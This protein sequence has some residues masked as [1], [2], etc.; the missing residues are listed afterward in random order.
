[1]YKV[2]VFLRPLLLCVLFCAAVSSAGAQALRDNLFG[3]TDELIKKANAE[4]AN[5]LAPQSYRKGINYYQDADSSFKK[6][7]NISDIR[8]DLDKA[9]LYIRKALETTKISKVTFGA[10]LKARADAEKAEAGKYATEL[11]KEA[12]DA[13]YDA[14]SELEEGDIKDARKQGSKAESQYRNAE[15]DAIK[16]NYLNETRTL[17]ASA[18]NMKIKNYA[19]KTL[20]KS[21]QL[22]AQAEQ[23]L[24]RNR[25]DTDLPHN[26]ARQAKYE[27][28]HAIYLGQRLAD[29]KSR[30]VSMEDLV[31][32]YETPLVKIAA[33][34]D[35]VAELDNG[36][37][38][39]AQKVVEYIE[40][41]QAE[42]E[43]LSQDV[44]VLEEKLGGFES[45]S[46]TLKERE[47][48]RR[49]AEQIEQLFDRNEA[50]VLRKGNDIIL[51]MIG[52]NFDVGK[53]EI[54]SQNFALLSKVKKAIA[55]FPQS[56]ITVEGHTDSHGGD[57]ANLMLSEQRAEAV[58]QY[59]VENMGIASSAVNSMG[60]GEAQPVANNETPEGRSKNRRID[61]VLNI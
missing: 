36:H 37:E 18:D 24:N 54:R 11:W 32:D 13:F 29:V 59:I 23:E 44:A 12:E 30:R 50:N 19:P 20:E 21:R 1:M 61:I 31:L 2:N 28:K 6:D 57:E 34:A 58:R 40:K 9:D 33:A 48:V 51:R 41:L 7:K 15:L 52:L 42:S 27:A 4:Q 5:V 26:L 14:A 35:K 3:D 56:K 22:L 8:K 39:T 46:K 43:R 45:E 47:L 49:K 17:L 53:S 38:E 25:Y 16:A 60:Y 55:M 10:T